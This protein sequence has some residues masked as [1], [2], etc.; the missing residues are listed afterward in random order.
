MS[1]LYADARALEE[2]AVPER[3]RRGRGGP[4]RERVRR[5]V[6]VARIEASSGIFSPTVGRRLRT[7]YTL[8]HPTSSNNAEKGYVRLLRSMAPGYANHDDNLVRA[9]APQRRGIASLRDRSVEAWVVRQ[10]SPLSLTFGADT[11]FVLH[12]PRKPC[13][14]LKFAESVCYV[15]CE[16]GD[17]SLVQ[18]HHVTRLFSGGRQNMD[19]L[20]APLSRKANTLASGLVFVDDDDSGY[21]LHHRGNRLLDMCEWMESVKARRIVPPA[22]IEAKKGRGSSALFASFLPGGI[23]D[24]L[25][26]PASDEL[27]EEAGLD[28]DGEYYMFTPQFLQSM[29]FVSPRTVL[30]HTVVERTD[31]ESSYS[32]MQ[33]VYGVCTITGVTFTKTDGK[34][35]QLVLHHMTYRKKHILVGFIYNQVNTGL[36]ALGDYK[37]K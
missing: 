27:L 15:S 3:P 24:D 25:V 29:P 6:S 28:D 33:L 22:W 35:M 12:N 4:P 13:E 8:S 16:A 26:E 32:V 30:K 18:P 14:G 9:S 10:D 21:S 1:Q 7:L 20:A 34:T 19:H 2:S 5:L 37:S 23:N 11:L 36:G 17:S 31:S